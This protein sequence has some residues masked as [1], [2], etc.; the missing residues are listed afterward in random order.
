MPALP[1]RAGTLLGMRILAG[2]VHDTAQT[3]EGLARKGV[4]RLQAQGRMKTFSCPRIHFLRQIGATQVVVGVVARIVALGLSGTLQP[5]DGLVEAAHLD[6]VGTDV[7]VGVTEV[8][9]NFD[10]ALALRDGLLQPALEVIRSE[11]HTS[12]LQSRSDL[13]C[14]LLLEKKKNIVLM[15]ML[16]LIHLILMRSD[17][18]LSV[19][20]LTR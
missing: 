18:L 13:V 6:Q 15:L 1:V 17:S 8:R 4:P 16:R 2:S 5:R 20:T 14:R 3:V 12:E 11:E 10:G 7:V 9:I 19:T